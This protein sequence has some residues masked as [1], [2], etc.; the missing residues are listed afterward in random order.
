LGGGHE[1]VRHTLGLLAAGRRQQRRAIR[2]LEIDG[3]DATDIDGADLRGAADIA[4]HPEAA[5]ADRYGQVVGKVDTEEIRRRV[6][7]QAKAH[8]HIHRPESQIAIAFRPPLGRSEAEA[9]VATELGLPVTADLEGS[10][11]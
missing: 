2:Q 1:R 11:L 8:R 6:G 10:Q 7:M 3:D 5:L 9:C 4:V